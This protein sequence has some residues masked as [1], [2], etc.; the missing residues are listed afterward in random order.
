MPD[1]VLD[2]R[3]ATDHFPGIGRYVVNLARALS[4]LS[5]GPDLS[6]L[7]NPSARATRL[8]LPA[9]SRIACTASPF[10]LRQQWLVPALLRRAQ[11]T[12]YHSSYY[13]M[14]YWTGVPTVLTCHDLIPLVSADHFG[15]AQQARGA[16]RARRA[17]YRLTNVLA[18]R[19]A[20]AIVAVSQAT[21]AD[22]L[23]YFHLD[24]RRIVVIP[25]AAETHFTPQPGERIAAVRQKYALPDQYVLYFGSN[26][27]HKNLVRL[28]K[29]WQISAF[30]PPPTRVAGSG[31][32]ISGFKLV[33]AGHWDSRYPEIKQHVETAGLKDHVIF[34][35]PVAEE[36]LPA[37]YSGATLFVFPSLY[38]G[39]GLPVLEA[40][41]CGTPVVCSNVSSLPEVAGDAARL[42]DPLDVDDLAA[43][44]SQALASEELRQAMLR[45]GM[46]QAAKF[47]W[48]QTARE[49]LAVYNQAIGRN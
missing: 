14:P 7:Y 1:C 22:L 30:R 49:T 26:K 39:F 37:L 36:D 29:A 47:S 3:T 19:A 11:A 18:L 17:V 35:G 21:K 15:A 10:S 34:A 44:I 40:M 2:A 42:A 24:S 27:P 41:S 43:T 4:Q 25:E 8:A 9:L 16:E 6:L 12:L 5:P 20:H 33:I 45:R 32:A 28:I 23:H 38:E 31:R 48:E 46:E 13:L